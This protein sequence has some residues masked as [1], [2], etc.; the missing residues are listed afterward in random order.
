[1]KSYHTVWLRAHPHRSSEWLRERL[2]EGFEVHHIDGVHSNNAP[3]NLVLVEG[4]DHMLLHMGHRPRRVREL[5]D[6]VIEAQRAAYIVG[7][8]AYKLRSTG[9]RWNAVA[10]ELY[11]I[12]VCEYLGA[13][14]VTNKA[15]RY[16]LY[17]DHLWP[18][19]R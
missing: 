10:H 11:R 13:S 7:E 2:A 9:L 19:G 14:G 8:A 3:A 16:A 5:P 18:V 12:G 17:N 15:R 4:R 6:K 1:M